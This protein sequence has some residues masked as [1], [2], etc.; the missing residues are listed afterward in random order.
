ML[1]VFQSHGVDSDFVGASR[2]APDA[3]CQNGRPTRT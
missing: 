2:N 1:H 3:A